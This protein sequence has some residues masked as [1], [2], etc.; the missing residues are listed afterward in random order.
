MESVLARAEYYLQQQQEEEQ[1]EN[2]QP[3]WWKIVEELEGGLEGA[4]REVCCL[5]G[6]ICFDLTLFSIF[7]LSLSLSLSLLCVHICT[8]CSRLVR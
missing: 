6:G 2:G 8:A 7:S 3:N 4:A 1:Q 5:S